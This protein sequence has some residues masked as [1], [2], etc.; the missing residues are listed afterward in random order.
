MLAINWICSSYRQRRQ[1]NIT[2]SIA[3]HRHR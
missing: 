3:T 2:I 1:N